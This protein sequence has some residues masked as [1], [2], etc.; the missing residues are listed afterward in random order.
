MLSAC[1]YPPSLGID[2]D[3]TS[4]REGLRR[5]HLG[6]VMPLARLLEAELSR[7]LEAEI[8]LKFDTYPL[9]V[10]SRAQ[11]VH[12][13]TAAGVALPVALAAVGLDDA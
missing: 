10:V 7:K 4:Q 6:T 11:V 3:G 2:A 9:D 12:K 8:R 13:L 5:W 1:G